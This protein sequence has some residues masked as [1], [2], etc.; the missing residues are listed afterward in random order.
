MRIIFNSISRNIENS[1]TQNCIQN[2]VFLV[3]K[4][5]LDVK[6]Q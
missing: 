4:N 1:N 5:I 6:F 2:W 3:E